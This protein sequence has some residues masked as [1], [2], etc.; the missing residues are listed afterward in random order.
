MCEIMIEVAASKGFTVRTPKA[1]K[2]M[3]FVQ[4]D[5]TILKDFYHNLPVLIDVKPI[6]Q[7]ISSKVFR[8]IIAK[9]QNI[10]GC[11]EMIVV[12]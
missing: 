9:V 12:G 3:K 6:S 2:S 4:H 7:I 5:C 1:D 10:L 11:L 8:Q